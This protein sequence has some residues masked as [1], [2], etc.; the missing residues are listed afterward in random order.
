MMKYFFTGLIG[1]FVISGCASTT[2]TAE[3]PNL[4]VTDNELAKAKWAELERFP[5]RYPK[6]AVINSLEGCATVEYVITP[7][8][9]V[10]DISV[11]ESTD[12]HFSAAAKDVVTN[13][14]WNEL[15]NNIVSEPVKTQTRFDFCMDKGNQACDTIEPEYS[16][17]GEDIIYS[18]GMAR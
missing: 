8:N 1:L 16:C 18:R 14:K 12:T 10:Q 5:A 7:D 2:T 17:P 9:Q 6:Q 3:Y 4:P 13:W 11:V 15:P